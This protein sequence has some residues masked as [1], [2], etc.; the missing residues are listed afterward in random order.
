MVQRDA[1]FTLHGGRGGRGIAYFQELWIYAVIHTMYL[2]GIYYE[3]I[4]YYRKLG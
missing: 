3:K 1:V 2:R 4:G